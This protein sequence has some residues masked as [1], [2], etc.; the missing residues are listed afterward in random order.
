MKENLDQLE[1]YGLDVILGRDKRL[2]ARLLRVVLHGL[3]FVYR[4]LVWSRLA[5]YR[6]RVLHEANLGCM[7]ISIGNLSVGGTGKTPVV[8]HFARELKDAGRNVVILSRGYKSKASK[9][10]AR[11]LRGDDDVPFADEPPPRVVSDGKNVL[12]PS[13]ES[14][15][16]P[17][18]LAK[19]LPDIPVVVDKNRVKGGVYAIREFG[20]DT[21]ILDDGLQYLKMRHRVDIL[22]I[23]KNAPFGNGYMLPRG[24]LREPPEN[25]K[26][27]SYVFI[28]KCTGV[29]DENAELIE[30][31]R[32]HNPNVEIIECTHKPQY[33]YNVVTGEKESLE[34]LKDKYV[35]AMSGI[36]Q[37]ESFENGL[38]RLGANL[39]PVARFADHH[40]FDEREI[41]DFIDVAVD[42]D[43]D[44]VLTTEKDA[45]RFPKLLRTDIP[46]Y[47][48]RIKIDILSGQETWKECVRRICSPLEVE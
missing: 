40:W 38:K 41:Q 10:K 48:L 39:G 14:G 21:L 27:A 2:K 23:D 35:A 25:V 33:L 32:K 16:E 15:D 5:M 4:G 8:E 28:T 42:S 3:S 26:R 34:L 45:V 44:M 31:I 29:R 37:P 17:F 6:Q 43:M 1:Q 36:A 12:L 30:C 13:L 22:L 11:R 7:V 18:M 46:I 19:N 9:K 20:A 24:T 47:Y